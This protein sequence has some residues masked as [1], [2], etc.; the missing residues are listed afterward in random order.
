MGLTGSVGKKLAK[1]IAKSFPLNA[2]R[3]RALRLAG[4]RVGEAVYIGEEFHVTDSLASDRCAL[5]IGDR[6]AIAQRVLVVL[7]SHPNHSRLRD[8]FGVVRG[9]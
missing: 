5:R 8:E 3:V 6:V 7:E 2:V 9:T 1:M 4:Y